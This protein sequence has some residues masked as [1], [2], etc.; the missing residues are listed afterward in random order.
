MPV[1]ENYQTSRGEFKAGNPGRPIGCLNKATR[2][3]NLIYDIIEKR[4]GELDVES[5]IEIAKI[6]A[7]FVPKEHNIT[8]DFQHRGFIENMIKKAEE[9]KEEQGGGKD[10]DKDA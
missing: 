6:A 5:I 9:L 10:G 7:K 3:K 2:F 1:D 4:R 8:G